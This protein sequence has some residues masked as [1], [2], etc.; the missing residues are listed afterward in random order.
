M[1]GKAWGDWKGRAPPPSKCGHVS[2][3]LCSGIHLSNKLRRHLGKGLRTSQVWRKKQDNWLHV[4]K[5]LEG[6]SCTSDLN[7]T[8]LFSFRMHSSLRMYFC[9]AS[10]SSELFLCALHTLCCVSNNKLCTLLQ[11]LPPC[12][13]LLSKKG[14][15][16]ATLLLASSPWWSSG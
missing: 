15:A 12:N 14:R 8:V 5:D 9:L 6:L 1:C 4:N 16:R 7:H 10:D 3:G 11:F 13:I 2:I